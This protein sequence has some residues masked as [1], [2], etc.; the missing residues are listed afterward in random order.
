ME[1]EPDSFGRAVRHV[2]E[3]GLTSRISIDARPV[4]DLP[5]PGSFDLVYF[6]DALHDQA[7]PV[8]ALRNA[9]TCVRPGGRLVVLDWCLPETVD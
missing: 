6:Q 1:L 4:D 5:W 7:D 8:G 9:W 3:A 2:Q